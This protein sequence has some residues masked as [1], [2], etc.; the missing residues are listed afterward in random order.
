MKNFV[1]Y[2]L[3]FA[4]F[5][6]CHSGSQKTKITNDIIKIDISK[7]YPQSKKSDRDV[8]ADIE[9][10][11]LETTKDVLVANYAS[12]HYVSEKYMIVTE[13]GRGDIFIFNRN[14]K[15][16]THLSRKGRGPEEYNAMFSVVFDEKNEEIFVFDNIG[17]GRV[18]VYS[19]NGE[20]RRTLRYSTDLSLTAYNFD[21]E[22]MLV[23]DT[24]NLNNDNYNKKPYMLMSKK[25]GDIIS[26][27]NIHLPVRYSTRVFDQFTDSSGQLWTSGSSFRI[28]NRRHD[29]EDF[30]IA[31][32]SSDTIYRL[33]RN[34]DLFPWIVRTPS[35]HSTEPRLVC[36]PVIITDNFVFLHITTLDYA[37]LQKQQSIPSKTLMYEFETGEISKV[38]HNS[39]SMIDTNVLQK[40]I[41]VNMIFADIFL[42]AYKANQLIAT[43]GLDQLVATLDEEDNPVVIIMKITQ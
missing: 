25:D 35:V 13:R 22:T 7:S 28:P 20:Y 9:Y 14:G 27:L 37:L 1:L 4:V 10:V 32:I 39:N 43:D 36:T 31:D 34:R 21:E 40:N 23:Y 11:P 18:L 33:T 41:V 15:I 5:Y 2:V 30:L 24:N 42:D 29:G 16:V 3:S 26:V 19:L 6:S 17:T 12:L 38:N 8:I